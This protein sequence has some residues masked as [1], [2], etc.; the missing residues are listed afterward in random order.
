M[1]LEWPCVSV[2]VIGRNEANLLP[3][4]FRSIQEMD[5]PQDCLEFLY[6]DT[7]STD[8]SLEIAR[9]YGIRA[10]QELSDFPTAALARNRGIREAKYDIV[11]FVDGDM[12]VA[13]D[14]L[15]RAIP[16]LDRDGVACVI[17]RLEERHAK[18]NLIAWAL[19]H[20]WEI[21][22]VGFVEAPGGGGTFLK[23]ALLDVGGY[24]ANLP[25]MAETEIG[26]RLREKG[27]RILL[28]DEVMGTHD[29][30]ITT[31]SQLLKWYYDRG[32]GVFGRILTFPEAPAWRPVQVVARKDLVFTAACL[33]LTVVLFISGYWFL[34]LLLPLA[35]VVYVLLRYWNYGPVE[36]RWH[37]LTFY[38]LVYIGKPVV[39]LGSLSY[40]VR[41]YLPSFH[42]R[43]RFVR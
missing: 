19:H 10:V 16:H 35:L 11:H 34:V 3:D 24:A 1:N 26:I 17:G 12:T 6:V 32:Y 7:G 29:Y 9:Q 25:G 36:K 43:I 5:Y 21:K 13:P 41:H 28:I 38:L 18:D 15:K 31:L 22:Q 2:V 20:G 8:D 37:T 4:C 30:E 27:H 23:S 40:L 39:A 14:Y 33:A 42:D